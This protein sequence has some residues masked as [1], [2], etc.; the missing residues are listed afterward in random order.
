[1]IYIN[2]ITL[3]FTHVHTPETAYPLDNSRFL[4]AGKLP[5]KLKATEMVEITKGHYMRSREG[6]CPSQK[7][8]WW[9]RSPQQWKLL[10][11]AHKNKPGTTTG[12]LATDTSPGMMA[13]HHLAWSWATLYQITALD[14]IYCKS[15]TT[16]PWNSLT[17]NNSSNRIYLGKR[18]IHSFFLDVPVNAND[19]P[20]T[21]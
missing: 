6:C 15:L 18:V 17:G 19:A 3:Y 13:W 16:T 10:P 9:V 7:W 1:M 21:R 5:S 2:N 4:V 20:S 8:R 11:H 12:P 14:P